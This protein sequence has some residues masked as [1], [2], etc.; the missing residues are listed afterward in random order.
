MDGTS[1]RNPR[2]SIVDCDAYVAQVPQW[3]APGSSDA[4]VNGSSEYAGA[5]VVV[6]VNALTPVNLSSSMPHHVMPL[7]AGSPPMAGDE[8]DIM[9][10]AVDSSSTNMMAPVAGVCVAGNPSFAS[11]PADPTANGAS[12]QPAMLQPGGANACAP[13][14]IPRETNLVED[15]EDDDAVDPNLSSYLQILSDKMAN[16]FSLMLDDNTGSVRL[17]SVRKT[18]PLMA[19]AVSNVQASAL[20]EEMDATDSLYSPAFTFSGLNAAA[21][22][23]GGLGAPQNTGIQFA[24][25]AHTPGGID[26][27]V[28]GIPSG[29]DIYG[30]KMVP[31]VG[32]NGNGVPLPAGSHVADTTGNAQGSAP[33]I[34]TN[35]FN[36]STTAVA[37]AYMTSQP[38]DGGSEAPNTNGAMQ[39]PAD[40]DVGANPGDDLSSV[41]NGVCSPAPATAWLATQSNAHSDEYLPT[42][43]H[44]GA[45]SN[46]SNAAQIPPQEEYM[47][48]D[49]EENSPGANTTSA[50]QDDDMDSDYLAFSG[51][52]VSPRTARLG[53]QDVDG[54]EEYLALNGSPQL[55]AGGASHKESASP[56]YGDE[57][58]LAL[59][60]GR[61]FPSSTS[62][63]AGNAAWPQ[64][65]Y[66]ALDGSG[67]RPSP[68]NRP[69]IVDD[70]NEA[71]MQFG[72]ASASVM[73][74]MKASQALEADDVDE[75][76]WEVHGAPPVNRA[77]KRTQPMSTDEY[78]ACD[79]GKRPNA[80]HQEEYLSLGQRQQD[81]VDVNGR[82]NHVGVHHAHK[83]SSPSYSEEEYIA[84][85]G[86]SVRNRK[87][88]AHHADA[89][90]NGALGD[91]EYIA[92]K[93]KSAPVH[94][95]WKEA[96]LADNEEEYIA[97][98]GKST[99][100]RR[101]IPLYSAEQEANEDGDGDNGT[102]DD[103][104]RL[105]SHVSMAHRVHQPD[106]TV[107]VN[108]DDV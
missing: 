14:A 24:Q 51:A 45:T 28:S 107:L 12:T 17:K 73:T 76:A 36:P 30:A 32:V 108:E 77:L 59:D 103:A 83:A 10:P 35:A 22:S 105:E 67:A 82:D 66:I 44:D 15:Y 81:Y 52:S 84:V 99:R 65:D 19:L 96:L 90:A 75:N 54:L 106:V 53:T 87:F 62:A 26:N 33:P 94:T 48:M 63:S 7:A 69:V 78:L 86:K 88:P 85:N 42:D 57:E 37:T 2:E 13:F 89:E 101:G 29:S 61:P 4:A 104:H 98:N 92:I 21:D 25:R 102:S 6:G 23:P 91:E 60:G 31:G 50:A 72:N 18:N 40:S 64:E 5:G 46:A 80:D 95:A 79:G 34:D 55:T 58:Y 43:G 11:A 9:L 56:P 39:P 47:N 70:D 97:V 16:R 3:L 1:P 74:A 20:N 38:V 8:D 68:T 71:Y 27:A 41:V 49:G 93:D 100:H